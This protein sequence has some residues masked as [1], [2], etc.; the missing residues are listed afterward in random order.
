MRPG[1]DGNRPRKGRLSDPDTIDEHVRS[2]EVRHNDN[3]GDPASQL[4]ELL[5]PL[6]QFLDGR[7]DGIFQETLERIDCLDVSS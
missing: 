5:L 6:A 3:V 7:V 1:L 2:V 4:L